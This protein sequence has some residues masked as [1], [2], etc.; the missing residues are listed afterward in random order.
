MA[1]VAI[2]PVHVADLLADGERMPVN[3]HVIDHPDGRVLVD[4]GMTELHPA[5][6]DMDPR[7]RPLDAQGFDIGG[8]GMV[9]NT[10]LH[11]DHC[12]GNRLF[13]GVPTYVQRR[14]LEDARTKDPY[15]IREWVDAP[16][17]TYAPVDGELEL[18][19]GI[20]LVPAPGHT[21]GSQIVVVDTREG[22]VVI[23][24]DTAVWFGELDDPQTQGQRLIRALDPAAVWLAHTDEPWRPSAG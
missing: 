8:V 14:E 2:T 4:T 19:P 7:L 16:G 5:V 23:A 24:G 21:P 6:A 10:H 9:V 11:F 18:L 20:R 3:V 15:T 13:A 1:D 22:R 17:V 12:G